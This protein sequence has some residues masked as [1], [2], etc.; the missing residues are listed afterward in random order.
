MAST[1]PELAGIHH[2]KFPV[3]DLAV[4]RLW[5]ERVFGLKVEMEFRDDHD[6]VVRGV[7]GTAPGLGETGIALREN[8]SAAAGYA[9]FDPVAFAAKDCAAIDAWVAHLDELG[10]EH[11]PVIEASI[12]W[13]ISFQ[14]PDG[15]ELRIYTWERHS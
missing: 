1:Q 13:I 7:A 12:G 8:P 15:I 3:R 14:D 10:V 9:G 5:Y 11:S 6:G 4:S 2:V